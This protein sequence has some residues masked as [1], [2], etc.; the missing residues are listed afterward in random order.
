MTDTQEG[1]FV[2]TCANGTALAGF[3]T[4]RRDGTTHA[5][6]NIPTWLTQD[7]KTAVLEAV[8]REERQITIGEVD[9]SIEVSWN[10]SIQEEG[11]SQIKVERRIAVLAFLI[12][13]AAVRTVLASSYNIQPFGN[14]WISSRGE[15]LQRFGRG[16][17]MGIGTTIQPFGSGWI[18]STGRTTMPF[19]QGWITGGGTTIQPFGRGWITSTGS[20]IQ[21]FGRGWS[22]NQ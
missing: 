5:T 16:W 10:R 11:V 3:L 19:G 7:V 12:L 20:T 8:T 1:N 18:S 2:V 17:I 6:P 15:T 13:L 14:G 22:V 4:R 21:P 9:Y